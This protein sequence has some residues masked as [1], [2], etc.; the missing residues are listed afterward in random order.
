MYCAAMAGSP[1]RR[2]TKFGEEVASLL[3]ENLARRQ[4]SQRELARK[5][6]IS[7]TQLNQYLRGLKSPTIE[8]F[9]DICNALII[10]PEV[11]MGLASYNLQWRQDNDVEDDAIV[12]IPDTLK[13]N[14]KNPQ[15]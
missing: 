1:R 3:R 15:Q 12:P 10:R 8:E 2:P 14:L 11:I 13:W 7:T 4:L 5:A 6:D 9:A